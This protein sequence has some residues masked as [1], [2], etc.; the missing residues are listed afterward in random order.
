LVEEETIMD[1]FRVILTRVL[2]LA[3]LAFALTT[4]G[5]AVAQ[6]TRSSPIQHGA[7]PNAGEV[8][9]SSPDGNAPSPSAG[10]LKTDRTPNRLLGL[11]VGFVVGAAIIVLV[12]STGVVIYAR[13]SHAQP[14]KRHI[15]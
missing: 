1:R 10:T 3:A 8:R 15:R 12:L 5:A 9:P 7:Q 6:E 11:P 13:R 4:V 14:G 2:T